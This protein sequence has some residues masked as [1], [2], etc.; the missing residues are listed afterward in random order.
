MPLDLPT[1]KLEVF[2][3]YFDDGSCTMTWIW[4]PTA[5]LPS[6]RAEFA[7]LGR[8]GT[9]DLAGDLAL[10]RARVAE[11]VATGLTPLTMEGV[12]DY[13][14]LERHYVLR[15]IPLKIATTYALGFFCFIAIGGMVVA[16]IVLAIVRWGSAA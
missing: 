11:L 5:V 1:C 13:L 3:T 14:R 4:L 10:H 8:I 2:D 12:D 15:E 6:Q 16:R 7:K 9:G